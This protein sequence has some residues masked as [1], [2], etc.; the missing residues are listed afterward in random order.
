MVVLSAQLEAQGMFRVPRRYSEVF[1]R[2]VWNR[3]C[4]I[5]CSKFA[6]LMIFCQSAR[7]ERVKI[8]SR[9]RSDLKNLHRIL[10]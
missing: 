5:F 3:K 6:K 10:Y 4:A 8:A 9:A 1:A 2:V 7:P